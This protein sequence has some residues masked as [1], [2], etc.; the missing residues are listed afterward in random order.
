LFAS[1]GGLPMKQ[2]KKEHINSLTLELI[3]LKFK[4]ID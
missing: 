4:F 1:A 2:Q 3:A